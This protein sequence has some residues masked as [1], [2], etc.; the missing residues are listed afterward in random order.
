MGGALR[1]QKAFVGAWTTSFWHEV[2]RPARYS[3][4]QKEHHSNGKVSVL[5][6]TFESEDDSPEGEIS[7][8]V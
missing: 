5:L 7:E 6:E 2:N 4:Q 8:A 1:T 3:D